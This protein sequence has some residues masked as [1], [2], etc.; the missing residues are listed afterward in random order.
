MT[1]G[2]ASSRQSLL[3]RLISDERFRLRTNVRDSD[4]QLKHLIISFTIVLHC[5]SMPWSIHFLHFYDVLF[6]CSRR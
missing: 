2:E 1:V 6:K 5:W 3:K 4:K